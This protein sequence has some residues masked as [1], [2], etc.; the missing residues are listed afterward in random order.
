MPYKNLNSSTISDPEN[1]AS[2]DPVKESDANKK[3]SDSPP[4]ASNLPV[5]LSKLFKTYKRREEFKETLEFMR[6]KHIMVYG[7]SLDREMTKMFCNDHEHSPYEGG[8]QFV[9][10]HHRHAYCHFE[11]Y[12]FTISSA[13]H[14]GL[15]Q[16]SWFHGDDD[17]SIGTHVEDRLETVVMPL[18]DK[19]G[20]PDLF[21]FSSG[22][23]GEFNYAEK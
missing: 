22:L 5:E 7:S 10:A 13:M 3:A 4:P 23:W 18:V 14:F 20:K 1:I 19:L 6:N 9:Y 12:N 17:P 15:H 21:V 11:D 2:Y 16:T 8:K